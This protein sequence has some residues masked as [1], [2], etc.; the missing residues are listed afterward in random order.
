VSDRPARRA[1]ATS[2][3]NWHRH[4]AAVVAAAAGFA[5]AAAVDTAGAFYAAALLAFVVWMLWF[6][7][8]AVDWI[9]RADF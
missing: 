3:R 5:V 4:L 9:R 2:L 6:V 8:T 7:L 1:L